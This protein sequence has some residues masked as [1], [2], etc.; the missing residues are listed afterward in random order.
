[1]SATI[2]QRR[3]LAD[4]RRLIN[5]VCPVCDGRHWIPTADTVGRCPR[6]PGSFVVTTERKPA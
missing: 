2:R 1:M 3:T 6:K 5:V 4:G